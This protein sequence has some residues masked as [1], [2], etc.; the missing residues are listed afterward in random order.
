MKPESADYLAKA[1]EY[2]DAAK[3]INAIPLPPVAAKEA[4]LA[5][6]HAAHAFVFESTGRALKN[7]SGMRTMFAQ[8]AKADP[9]VDR[10]LASLLA[11]AYKY[12]E[13]ADYGVG[14]QSVVTVKEAQD[15]IAIAERFLDTIAPLLPPGVNPPRCLNPKP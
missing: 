13:T 5:A 4:Y 15:V 6:Y 3:T 9:R 7:H 8:A 14:S 10:K 11:R 1:C 12:K 2:L